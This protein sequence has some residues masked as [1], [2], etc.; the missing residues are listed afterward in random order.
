LGVHKTDL[1]HFLLGE[2]I[3]EVSATIYTLSKTFSDGSHIRRGSNQ[4]H[5]GDICGGKIRGSRQTNYTRLALGG[6]T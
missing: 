6:R 1:L 4:G 3:V 2:S 5:A